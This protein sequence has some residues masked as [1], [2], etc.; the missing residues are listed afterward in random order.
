M[1]NRT[2]YSSK[3][4]KSGILDGLASTGEFVARALSG[5]RRNI[6]ER[7]TYHG[8]GIRGDV[9]AVGRDMRKSAKAVLRER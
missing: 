9:K 8:E 1:S 4:F 7:A 3:A 2:T 5:D 6:R